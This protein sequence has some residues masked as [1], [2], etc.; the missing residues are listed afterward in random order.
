[1]IWIFVFVLFVG[2]LASRTTTVMARG[3]I[4]ERHPARIMLSFFGMISTFVTLVTGFFL[5]DWWMPIV[6]FLV[7]SVAVGFIAIGKRLALLFLSA[8]VQHAVTIAGA[9]YLGW[10]AWLI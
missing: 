6:A 4:E 7:I 10:H 1:M 5:F 2:M 9:G 8:P 3:D